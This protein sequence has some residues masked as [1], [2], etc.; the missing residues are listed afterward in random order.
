MGLTLRQAA[1]MCGRS[2]ST[3]HRALKNGKLSGTRSDDGTWSI[4]PSELSRVFPWDVTGHAQRDDKEHN[5]PPPRNEEAAVLRI[6][7]EMLGQQLE[8]EKDTVADLRRRLDKA[9]ERV[10]LL[11]APK[12]PQQQLPPSQPIRSSLLGRL[13]RALKGHIEDH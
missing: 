13:K 7:V 6:K 8:R 3:I 2:R 11:S 9:E 10:Y 12:E 1:D 5:A 4:D